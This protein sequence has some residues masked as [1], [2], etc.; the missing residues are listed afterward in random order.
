MKRKTTAAAL[1]FCLIFN[2]SAF[3]FPLFSVY[4]DIADTSTQRPDSIV[5]PD[6][7]MSALKG[8]VD[9]IDSIDTNRAAANW[10]PFLNVTSS[11]AET[12]FPSYPFEPMEGSR[13]LVV[14]GAKTTPS[15]DWQYIERTFGVPL[16]LSGYRSF[17]YA[18]SVDS[19]PGVA[20]EASIEFFTESGTSKLYS[21]A[22]T[23]ES[24]NGIFCDISTLGGRDKIERI[25]IGV[26]CGYPDAPADHIYA[27]R[28]D[29]IAAQSDRNLPLET[30]FMSGTYSIYGGES[31]LRQL[32]DPLRM[33]INIS[34][35]LASKC[36]IESGL[37]TRD[38]FSSANA[39]R[40]RMA[41]MSS[42][43]AVVMQYATSASP[44]YESNPEVRIE[45]SPGSIVNAYYFNFPADDVIQVRFT[46][47][48]ASDGDIVIYSIT[49]VNTYSPMPESYPA[50]YSTMGELISCRLSEDGSKIIISG[51][52][53]SNLVSAYKNSLLAVYELQACDSVPQILSG[54][55][56]P[57]EAPA[58]APA[59]D[60]QI[61]INS[62]IGE[63]SRLCSRFA[64][65]IY[66]RDSRLIIL[67]DGPRYI[68]NPEVLAEYRT[69][70]ETSTKKGI[71]SSAQTILDTGAAFTALKADLGKMLSD[72]ENES[73]A[74]V[75][76][77]ETF[78]IDPEYIS[79][80]DAAVF[81]M[82]SSG[83]SVIMELVLSRPSDK[84]LSILV[85]PDSLAR[86]PV[87]Y[88]AFNTETE[89]GVRYL[90]ALT[91]F[92]AERYMSPKK[93]YGLVASVTVGSDICLSWQNYGMGKK[94]PAEFTDSYSGAFR[95][96]YNTVRSV[97]SRVWVYASFGNTW[98][99][100]YFPDPAFSYCGRD[101]C[102]L[103][104]AQMSEEGAI[105]WRAALNP[106][107]PDSEL[108]T[109]W[110]ASGAPV[111][112]Y[113]TLKALPDICDYMENPRLMNE[114]SAR[115]ILLLNSSSP[116]NILS[117]AEL[118]IAEYVAS[119]F[120][121]CSESCAYTDGYVVADSTRFVSPDYDFYTV[122]RYIDT[123][124]YSLYTDF[125]LAMLGVTEW[126]A[127]IPGYRSG[128]QAGRELMTG[129]ISDFLPNGVT[130]SVLLWPF[131]T[132]DESG[133]WNGFSA[134]A[135]LESAQSLKGYRDLMSVSFGDIG[136]SACAV[137]NILEYPR[138]LSYAPYLSFYVY[139]DNLDLS[140]KQL[141][142]T[143]TLFSG[144][145]RAEASASVSGGMW[146]YTVCDFT[147]FTGIKSVDSI[148][149]NI[150]SP[151]GSLDGALFVL[152]GISASSTKY[153]T[154]FLESKF[155][156]EKNR[157]LSAGYSGVDT[158]SV[159]VTAMVA[160]I[161]LTA[162][163]MYITA[164]RRQTSDTKNVR[165]KYRY[166]PDEW[167]KK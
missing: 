146:S 45:I 16:D 70:H 147:D 43:S 14:T 44:A 34:T 2:L 136:E 59:T 71:I 17:F 100:N 99:K 11:V 92:L 53:N 90:R 78:Y 125:A 12:S 133:G 128:L 30:Q 105:A 55:L 137:V 74:Y 37:L 52:L 151:N 148:A 63:R 57:A 126:G 96:I 36:F 54:E 38:L 41:N 46:F 23:P 88:Y 68:T 35:T 84:Y 91:A 122:L 130:G 141:T 80:L 154:S 94:T 66:N 121:V 28:V 85:H 156:E 51:R 79:S 8:R 27:F 49:P 6:I 18:V 102:D 25:R 115:R 164:R 9:I 129:K 89:D 131:D 150:K 104:A 142:L 153:D 144:S 76:E 10:R 152:G 159:I 106:Y 143:V 31:R 111:R 77:N 20:Y 97:Y 24:W 33:E 69:P 166:T 60:F 75:F 163:I 5:I 22:V 109:D 103:F 64:V 87:N 15:S 21:A 67:I 113:V 39:V 4:A 42:C 161:A 1:L 127:L 135:A 19:Y 81:D 165:R 32:Y 61:T 26:K 145:S 50:E 73:S 98:D 157:Y 158:L 47:E 140:I 149:V 123:D 82:Y 3:V 83:A 13:C 116:Q 7:A 86:T 72:T 107:A 29:C 160:M 155:E 108:L 132:P 56:Q 119:Y 167:I 120:M 62:H 124:S 139:T 101:L 40:L 58:V 48:G 118:Y 95:I 138:D 134:A 110:K 162:E 65:A 93:T 114:T 117:S 112:E